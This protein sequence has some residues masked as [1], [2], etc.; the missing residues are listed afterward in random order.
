MT[1]AFTAFPEGYDV[2]GYMT[3]GHAQLTRE[4][5]DETHFDVVA[6]H[7]S[8]SLAAL[9]EPPH[10]VAEAIAVVA[11]LRAVFKRNADDFKK[12]TTAN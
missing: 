5:L 6:Q 7:L 4:G 8:G 11:P 10:L 1:M 9:G 2:D 12:A 3:K